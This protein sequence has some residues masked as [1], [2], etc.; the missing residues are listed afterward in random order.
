MS[1]DIELIKAEDCIKGVRTYIFT[2]YS[3][4]I[5]EQEQKSGL[6]IIDKEDCSSQKKRWEE[7]KTRHQLGQLKRMHKEAAMGST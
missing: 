5:I 6:Q 4:E 3:I 7:K 1:M 2:H